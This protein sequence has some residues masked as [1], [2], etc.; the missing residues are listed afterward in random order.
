M[1]K[2]HFQWVLFLSSFW[3]LFAQNSYAQNH[4]GIGFQGV[5][6]LPSGE[7]PT[8]AGLTVNARI[9]S[10]NNCILREEQFTG[11]NIS[12]GYINV[13]IGTGTT[14][15]HNPN[16]SLKQVMSNASLTC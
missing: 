4:K 5:I 11:V 16:L 2:R 8:R 3:T 15:G 13:A 9:L 7:L 10:P 14:G 1:N 12:N 6:K